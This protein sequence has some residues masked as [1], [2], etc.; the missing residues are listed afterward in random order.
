MIPTEKMK[1]HTLY[2]GY[3]K[4][5][6]FKTLYYFKYMGDHNDK[7]HFNMKLYGMQECFN[8]GEC[9]TIAESYVQYTT[10]LPYENF[11]FF[12]ITFEDLATHVIVEVI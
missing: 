1:R 9:C 2:M 12:E 7:K 6:C 3:Y 10:Y 4:G 5:D 8:H 11:E